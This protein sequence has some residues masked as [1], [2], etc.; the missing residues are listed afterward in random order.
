MELFYSLGI[1]YFVARWA[2]AYAYAVRGY[3]AY[4]GEYILILMTFGFS[5]GSIHAFFR[6]LR[7]EGCL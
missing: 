3:E 6:S 5:F 4:G 2:I 7:E 1:T